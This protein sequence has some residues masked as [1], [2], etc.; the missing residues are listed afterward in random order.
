LFTGPAA[1]QDAA[2]F[3]ARVLAIAPRW[4]RVTPTAHPVWHVEGAGW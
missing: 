3:T 2:A 4:W 1:G